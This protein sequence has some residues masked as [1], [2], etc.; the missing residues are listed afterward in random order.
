MDAATQARATAPEIAEGESESRLWLTV[1]GE[2]RSPNSPAIGEHSGRGYQPDSGCS[3]AG[4]MEGASVLGRAGVVRTLL[5]YGDA[6]GDFAAVCLP[7]LQR[8]ALSLPHRC[9]NGRSPEG[10]SKS[11][12]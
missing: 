8:D 1:P 9:G 2:G 10:E 11:H 6:G 4:R 5:V 7:G 3:F 12:L